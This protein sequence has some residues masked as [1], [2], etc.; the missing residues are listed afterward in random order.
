MSELLRLSS[1]VTP[2]DTTGERLGAGEALRFVSNVE[3]GKKRKFER[4]RIKIRPSRGRVSARI[5]T[6]RS[7]EGKKGKNEPRRK[8]WC[9]AFLPFLFEQFCGLLVSP[10]P[11]S[12]RE[13]KRRSRVLLVAGNWPVDNS[14][15]FRLASQCLPDP[16]RSAEL[17][18]AAEALAIYGGRNFSASA[19]GRPSR[20]RFYLPAIPLLVFLLRPFMIIT[21]HISNDPFLMNSSSSLCCVSNYRFSPTRTPS[22]WD[23]IRKS[24]KF[25]A[26]CPQ[27]LPSIHNEQEALKKMPKGRLEYLKRLLPFLQNQSEDCLYLNVFSPLHGKPPPPNYFFPLA[28]FALPSTL[29]LSLFSLASNSSRAGEEAASAGLHPRGVL[30]V[31]LGEPLRRLRAGQLR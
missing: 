15:T 23:G 13:I 27:R 29:S 14:V 9:L 1:V 6:K 28:G 12:A 11:F 17:P 5:I 16:D 20:G 18:F 30:R 4:I 22:P 3:D 8:L 10:S 25:S 21:S 24:D 31:E 19:V 2:H 7:Q 26:V